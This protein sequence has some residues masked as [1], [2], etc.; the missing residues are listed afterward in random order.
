MSLAKK[1]TGLG[2]HANLPIMI[3][4]LGHG[5]TGGDEIAAVTCEFNGVFRKHGAKHQLGSMLGLDF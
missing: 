4:G 3:V 5:G 1:F 2:W